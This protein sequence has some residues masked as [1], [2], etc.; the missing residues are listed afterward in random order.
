MSPDP[1]HSGFRAYELGY[2]HIDVDVSAED[3]R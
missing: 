3:G 2:I 1:K